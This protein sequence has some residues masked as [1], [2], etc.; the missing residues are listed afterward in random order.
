M[1]LVQ[2]QRL[3]LKMKFLLGY[4]MKIVA[5]LGDKHLEGELFSVEEDYPRLVL[6]MGFYWSKFLQ[7]KIRNKIN[8]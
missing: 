7:L 1:E 5:L 2:E 3:Q 6:M 4:N 8:L